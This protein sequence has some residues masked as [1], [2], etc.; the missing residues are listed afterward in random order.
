MQPRKI[1]QP[2]HSVGFLP[3]YKEEQFTEQQFADSA[4]QFEFGVV[5]L[6]PWEATRKL[7]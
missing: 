1:I 7:S 4:A 2:I 6:H 5:R 3:S